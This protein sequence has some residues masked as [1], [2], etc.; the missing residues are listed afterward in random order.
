M[1]EALTGS[2]GIIGTVAIDSSTIKAR[3]SAGGGTRGAFGEAIGRSRGGRT[4]RIHALTD[5]AGRPRI[6]LL[7]PGNAYDDSAS[8]GRGGGADQ[9]TARRQSL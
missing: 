8:A 5:A 4:T 6:L 9:Q 3:R 7:S 2:T 1:F